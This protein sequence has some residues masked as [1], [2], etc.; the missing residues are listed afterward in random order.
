MAFLSIL[1]KE[2]KSEIRSPAELISKMRLS[3]IQPSPDVS[4]LEYIHDWKAFCE[5]TLAG[6]SRALKN[7]TMYNSFKWVKE[8]GIV[9]FRGKL[10]PQHTDMSYGPKNGIQILVPDICYEAIKVA[11]FR[12]EKLE[13]NKVFLSLQKYFKTLQGA[14]MMNVVTS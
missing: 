7:H 5:K 12:I 14:D 1:A 10:M 9:R 4:A 11:E 8:E 2:F 13:L 6:G 3:P